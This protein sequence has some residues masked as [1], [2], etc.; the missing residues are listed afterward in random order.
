MNGPRDALPPPSLSHHLER[1]HGGARLGW[2][3]LTWNLQ[4]KYCPYH[5]TLQGSPDRVA[6]HLGYVMLLRDECTTLLH[7]PNIPWRVRAP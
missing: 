2:P 1:G 3:L 4:Q 7:G 6:P 5:L